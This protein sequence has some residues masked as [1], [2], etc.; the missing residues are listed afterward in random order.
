MAPTAAEPRAAGTFG[1][2]AR[3]PYDRA[4]R[5]PARALFLREAG[6]EPSADVVRLEIERFLAG[7]DA[8]DV[9]V[10]E[11]ATGPVLDIGCGPGRM[12]HAAI[13]A[14][15]MTLGIDISP[16][17]VR[18]AQEHGLPVLCRSI[19][20][21]LPAEGDW[22]TVLLIDGNIGIGGDP[23]ALL[24][25]CAELVRNV[26]GRIFVEAH[27]ET[28][29][30]RVFDG[31]VVDDLDRESLPFPWAEVGAAALRRYARLAGLRPL[32]TWMSAGRPFMELGR[33]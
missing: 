20:Q 31:V 23:R 26:G 9:A 12:V 10:V 13:M 19:F 3:E 11:D 27:R 29:R 15:H 7:A 18:L 30:D 17:A 4:L 22:G 33:A 2:G 28:A 1:S 24:A 8:S 14:G 21:G 16:T 32:R 25:R 6:A 5:D